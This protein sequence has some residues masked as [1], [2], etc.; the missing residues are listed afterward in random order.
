MRPGESAITETTISVERFVELFGDK[1]VAQITSNDLFDYR[2][3]LSKMPAGIS[4]PAV[5][6]RGMSLRRHVDQLHA[7]EAKREAEANL[8]GVPVPKARRLSPQSVKKDV[9][10]LSA[11]FNAILSERWILENLAANVRIDGYSKRRKVLALKPSMMKDLF[12]SPM[13]TGCE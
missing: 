5:K 7:D 8:K 13:F 1:H 2:H 9:G 12:E 3:F 6:A 10:G 11:T 4:L